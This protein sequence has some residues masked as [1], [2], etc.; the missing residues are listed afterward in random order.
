MTHKPR[1]TA[2]ALPIAEGPLSRTSWGFA[3]QP[4]NGGGSDAG[5]HAALV[6]TATR[7]WFVAIVEQGREAEFEAYLESE[8]RDVVAWLDSSQRCEA[9]ERALGIERA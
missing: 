1:Q 6:R 7:E 8:R 2:H 3:T 9:L 5:L 4:L